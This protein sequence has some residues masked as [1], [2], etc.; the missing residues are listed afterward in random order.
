MS[1]RPAILLV[2]LGNICRS[3][4]AEGAFRA[5]AA[6]AGVIAEIDSAGTAA[7]HVGKSPDPRSIAAARAGGVDISRQRARQVTAEDF[8][9]F[10]HI[11]AMDDTNL[12]D[13]EAMAPPG[14]TAEVHLLLDLVESRAGAS[15]IDP[16]YGDEEMF[17]YTW[18]AVSEA[19]R[20]FFSETA[21]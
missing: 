3:P 7:W 12:A 18:D 17:A 9:R 2:C 11:F 10:T 19:A 21:G 16:Y 6:R 1:D 13:L 14:A 4:L 8:A 15:V 20:Q 5:E